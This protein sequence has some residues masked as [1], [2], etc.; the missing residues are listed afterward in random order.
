MPVSPAATTT[1]FSHNRVHMLI[2]FS[3]ATQMHRAH[4]GSVCSW[5]VF[6]QRKGGV[7]VLVR[8]QQVGGHCPASKGPTHPPPEKP[9]DFMCCFTM[10]RQTDTVEFLAASMFHGYSLLL[11]GMERC[12]DGWMDAW[13]MGRGGGGGE[14]QL[15]PLTN[16]DLR[17]TVEPFL[18]SGWGLGVKG[19]DRFYTSMSPGLLWVCV[20]VCVWGPEVQP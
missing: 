13:G 3:S 2:F 8:E 1:D 18:T 7:G 12:M 20:C 9:S 11:V 10:Q 17:Q 4:P 16:I 19:S 15:S 14:N 6:L 5:G